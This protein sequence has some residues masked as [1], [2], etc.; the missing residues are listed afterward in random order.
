MPNTIGSMSSSTC[1]QSTSAPALQSNVPSMI[2]STCVQSTCSALALQSNVSQ[3]NKSNNPAWDDDFW[4]S[5]AGIEGVESSSK[6][7][8]NGAWSLQVYQRFQRLLIMCT[9]V[10]RLRISPTVLSLLWMF[11]IPLRQPM[12]LVS[13]EFLHGLNCRKP[14]FL[15]RTTLKTF[16]RS[17]HRRLYSCA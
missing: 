12:C 7:T 3:V 11:W 5:S 9:R 14:R 17:D 6:S 15:Q 2:N 1:V 10:L 8:L 16:H 4:A 13:L